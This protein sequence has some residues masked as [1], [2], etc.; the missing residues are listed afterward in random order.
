[1]GECPTRFEKSAFPTHRGRRLLFCLDDLR[2]KFTRACLAVGA[3]GLFSLSP[4]EGCHVG[5]NVEF[6]RETLLR[7]ATRPPSL[8]APKTPLPLKSQLNFK[9]LSLL[10]GAGYIS[11]YFFDTVFEPAPE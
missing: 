4:D 5:R 1:M 3:P 2:K 11:I 10:Y 6:D 7:E 9:S 8:R